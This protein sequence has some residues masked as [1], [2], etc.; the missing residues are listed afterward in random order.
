MNKNFAINVITV[1]NEPYIEPQ[2]LYIGCNGVSS[3]G[4]QI[5]RVY[6]ENNCIVARKLVTFMY[7]NQLIGTQQ[8]STIDNF[9]SYVSSQCHCCEPCYLL[10]NG[11]N[12][13]VNGCFITAYK[14]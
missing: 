4:Y 2:V 14:N 6:D 7:G 12:L 13:T 10:V 5:Q 3:L 1:D 8:F 9:N 11:C